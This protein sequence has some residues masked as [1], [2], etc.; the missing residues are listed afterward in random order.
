MSHFT[1]ISNGITVTVLGACK[2]RIKGNVYS[3][4]MVNLTNVNALTRA[5]LEL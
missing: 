4:A 3:M 5:L 2:V 1:L